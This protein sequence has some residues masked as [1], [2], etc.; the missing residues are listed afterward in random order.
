MKILLIF[1]AVFM[2]F[3]PNSLTIPISNDQIVFQ[4]E[5]TLESSEI[6]ATDSAGLAEEIVNMKLESGEFFQGDIVLSPDQ[7]DLLSLNG[8][9]DDDDLE[10]RTGILMESQRWT[11]N[12]A[13]FAVMPYVIKTTDYSN[14]S[15]I[16]NQLRYHFNDFSCKSANFDKT[17][18]GRH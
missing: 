2:L 18:D 11:K 3:V 6:L 14:D 9:A 7:E 5:N 10:S 4:E 15:R 17:C 16:F 1:S 8:T 13:G 12:A